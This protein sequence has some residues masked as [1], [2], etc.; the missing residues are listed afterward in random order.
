MQGV[1]GT[2]YRDGQAASTFEANEGHASKGSGVL[3]LRVHVVVHSKDPVATMTCDELI[4]DPTK[5][6]LRAKGAVRLENPGYTL[7]EFQE[8]LATPDLRSISTPDT[9]QSK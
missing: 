9:F 4:W 8:L 5:G 6:F 7:G 3:V 1:T 2:I